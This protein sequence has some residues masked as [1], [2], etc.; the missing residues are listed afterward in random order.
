M[1]NQ[2]FGFITRTLLLLLLLSLSAF[3]HADDKPLIVGSEQDYPPFALGLTDATADGFTV[4]LWRAV[5]AESHLNSSIRVLPF[6]EILQEFKT[7]NI[8][9]L[10]N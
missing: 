2:A 1:N 7:G 4:E 3:S 9:V 5:A 10:I 8:D 6:H